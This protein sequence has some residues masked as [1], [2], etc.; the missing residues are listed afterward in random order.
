LRYLHGTI[1]YGLIYRSTKYFRIIVYT[2][3]YWASC[4]DDKKSTLGY[5]FNMGS[6]IVAWSTK[7]K[8]T[9]FLSTVEEKYTTVVTVACEVVWLRR[10]LEDVH[11]Q[12]KQP[13]QLICDN[14]SV[15]QM[16]KN[17]VFYKNTDHINIQ[18]HFVLYLF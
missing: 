14:E 8:P 2:D 7:K 11:E 1:G 9:V 10:I 12:P 18:Y 17:L 15:I 16:T 5:S 3:S 4:I 13:I 6:T